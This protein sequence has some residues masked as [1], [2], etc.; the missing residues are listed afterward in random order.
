MPISSAISGSNAPIRSGWV[1]L[2][3]GD[4]E[5]GPGSYYS[6]DETVS[7]AQQFSFPEDRDVWDMVNRYEQPKKNGAYNPVVMLQVPAGDSITVSAHRLKFM[8]QHLDASTGCSPLEYATT[9]QKYCR[10]S[11]DKRVQ[12][13]KIYVRSE[14]WWESMKGKVDR[15]MV[16]CES[17]AAA[18]TAVPVV[19][20][21]A[22]PVK[23]Y[24]S[25]NNK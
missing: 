24:I 19:I 7:I 12:S 4:I 13:N 22:V 20:A 11:K 1:V 23:V 17:T 16:S 15:S 21:E 18:A 8:Y 2:T 3:G 10:E 25:P 9:V 14:D 5:I 6:S